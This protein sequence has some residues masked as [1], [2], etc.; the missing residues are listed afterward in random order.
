MVMDFLKGSTVH[1][2]RNVGADEVSTPSIHG[3][4]RSSEFDVDRLQVFKHTG[5]TNPAKDKPGEE[6]YGPR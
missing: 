5:R 4:T 2:G 3:R 1:A 6:A